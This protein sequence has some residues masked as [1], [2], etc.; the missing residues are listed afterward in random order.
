MTR[1]SQHSTDVGG[2]NCAAS[3]SDRRGGGIELVDHDVHLEVVLAGPLCVSLTHRGRRYLR[4]HGPPMTSLARTGLPR[5]GV[6]T[7][8]PWGP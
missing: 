2:I 1:G 5:C 4:A 6:L 7:L 3:G 8:A